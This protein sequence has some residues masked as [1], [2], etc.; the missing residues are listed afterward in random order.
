MLTSTRFLNIRGVCLFEV[1]TQKLAIFRTLEEIVDGCSEPLVNMYGPS[2]GRAG[3]RDMTAAEWLR[4]ARAIY[5]DSVD[6]K[7]IAFCPALAKAV[8]S[9]NWAC[10]HVMPF[11][12]RVPKHWG[13]WVP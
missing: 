13:V 1:L 8:V 10:V 12:N 7:Q 5:G 2:F 6:V 11:R 3:D 9:G 4:R